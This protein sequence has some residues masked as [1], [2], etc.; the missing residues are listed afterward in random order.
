M[1]KSKT[2]LPPPNISERSFKYTIVILPPN[3]CH[4]SMSNPQSTGLTRLKKLR[5][6]LRD[7]PTLA[8][9]VLELHLSEIYTLYEKA[10]LEKQEIVNQVASL[11]M[12]TP[13]LERLVGFQVP[14]THS[15]DRLSHAL[16]TRRNL[17]EKIWLLD[18]GNGDSAS[19]E[20]EDA[21]G[22]YY[23][24]SHDPT[25]RFLLLNSN[26]DALSTL[27]LQQ[28]QG[29]ISAYL[30]FRSIIGTLRLLPNLRHLVL[31]GLAASVFTNLAL[32]ALPAGLQSLRLG[33]LA[34]VN[35]R[36]LQR[37]VQSQHARSIKKLTLV[38]LSLK[39]ITTLSEIFSANVPELKSFIIAQ[40][41]AP[42]LTA[43]TTVPGFHS[44][45]LHFIHWDFRSEAGPPP[46]L[47]T[48]S[49]HP[50]PTEQLRFPFKTAEP[51][52]C[53]A[54]SLLCTSIRDG[55]FPSLRRIRIPH[56]PQ[57]LIQDLCKPLAA[58]LAPH[59][60][61]SLTAASR[62]SSS[63][64]S[65]IEIG[66]MP[67]AAKVDSVLV[68]AH[69]RS[70]ARADA[71][72]GPALSTSKDAVANQWGLSP[73]RS[74]VAAHVRIL[75]ARREEAMAIRVVGPDGRVCVDSALAGYMGDVA[76]RISYELEADRSWVFGNSVCGSSDRSEWLADVCDLVGGAQTGEQRRGSCRHAVGRAVGRGAVRVADLF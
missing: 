67:C 57:G 19:Q 23:H 17:R 60:V 2:G 21:I 11:V 9:Y 12:A 49:S 66:D 42:T 71:V 27:V 22:P 75:A 6:T 29:Q 40:D 35:D 36:G 39:S 33:N 13:N 70:S 52:S 55:A 14:L 8:R 5:R 25:E 7:H 4:T 63:N 16:S 53:L 51:I 72:T 61:A 31:S 46:R 15:F 68:T 65:D 3:D 30:S 37:F 69:A 1:S 20:E 59:E 47:P 56:D 76:S 34:G 45:N 10:E 43:Y 48:S 62:I 74:R 41:R 24:E 18:P 28:E 73:L 32:G 38:N 50:Y 64:G 58:A 54:T 26:H 44:P